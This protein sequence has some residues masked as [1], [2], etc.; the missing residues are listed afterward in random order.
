M[1]FSTTS[2]PPHRL[3]I[4]SDNRKLIKIQETTEIQERWVHALQCEDVLSAGSK[5]R[6]LKLS[7]N[8]L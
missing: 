3:D 7:E 1:P 6:M 2:P 8:W 5:K 4:R